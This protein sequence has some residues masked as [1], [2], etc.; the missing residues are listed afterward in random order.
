MNYE[1]YRT[2]YHLRMVRCCREKPGKRIDLLQRP[3]G[4]RFICRVY[5]RWIPAYAQLMGHTCDALP[6]IYRCYALDG[7][8]L[9]EEE[10]VDGVP[11]S[12]LSVDNRPDAGQV[13][14]LA[15]QV[16]RALEV[17]HRNGLVHRDVKPENVLLTSSGRVVLM[18]LDASC[19]QKPETDR[20]TQLLGTVGY[21]A[22]EQFGFGR[23][24]SRADLFSL[25]VMMNMLLTGQHPSRSLADGPLG[26]VIRT[27][28]QVNVD[29]RYPSAAAL[30]HALPGAKPGK[31]CTSCGFV[32]PG[33]GCIYCGK[34]SGKRCKR[35][36]AAVAAAALVLLVVFALQRPAST[37]DVL[38]TKPLETEGVVVVPE[39][40]EQPTADPEQISVAG[41][42]E[43]PA[44]L[45]QQSAE[46]VFACGGQTYCMAPVYWMGA[47][48]RFASSHQFTYGRKEEKAATFAIGL[49]KCG[50]ENAKLPLTPQERQQLQASF[51][52]LTLTVWA[53]GESQSAP[54]ACVPDSTCDLPAAVGILFD[55]SAEGCWVLLAEGKIEGQTVRSA[56]P[57][58]WETVERQVFLPDPALPADV[59]T[60][61]MQ[62]LAE[63]PNE[64]QTELIV[65]LPMGTFEGQLVIPNH[66]EQVFIVGA[67]ADGVPRTVLQGGIVCDSGN[68]HVRDLEFRGCG[69]EQK[70]WPNG[71]RNQALSGNGGGDYERCVFSGYDA[72]VVCTGR[73]RYGGE[74][75]VF[76]DNAVAVLLASDS[77]GGGDL[78]IK[79]CA[80]LENDVAI[81]FRK[82]SDGLPADQL[83]LTD[84]QFV[85]NGVDLR[86][87]VNGTFVFF[88]NLFLHDNVETAVTEAFAGQFLLQEK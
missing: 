17:L 55:A 75:S 11:L 30:L 25:G 23:S 57:V 73:L 18:D 88:D 1:A 87:E 76:R 6:K 36:I 56:V 21:A 34:P 65:Q 67:A 16:C 28:V 54:L 60:Q 86:S 22:P 4:T 66:L 31:I 12:E 72:A 14:A 46:T 71:V 47:D 8:M 26:A 38:Q 13:T 80:F 24:D 3:D 53:G 39:V 7:G 77:H 81:W 83:S 74:H 62:W 70:Y 45:E 64:P 48:T 40:E 37:A 61:T 52:Q 68:C 20:D 2:E 42:W 50:E 27:C 69:K 19:S 82:L 29:Q 59:L 58:I 84:T 32:T 15:A 78:R 35:S 51:E 79:D 5:D 43:D 41:I 63:Q 9:V 85:D 10:F 49:W 33:G 44:I